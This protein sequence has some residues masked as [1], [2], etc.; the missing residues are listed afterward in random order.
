MSE[1]IKVSGLKTA[2]DLSARQ[3]KAVQISASNTVATITNGNA[4]VPFGV[5]QNNPVGTTANPLSAEVVTFGETKAVAG[6]T[7]TAGNFLSIDNTGGFIAAPYETSPATADLYICAVALES[8]VSG[9]TFRI[10]FFPGVK[11]STE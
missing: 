6:G 2:T 3:F 8:A 4:E 5:L 11:A 7:I 9:D 1:N 10:H